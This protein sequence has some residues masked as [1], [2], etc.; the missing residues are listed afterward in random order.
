[1]FLFTKIFFPF[2]KDLFPISFICSVRQFL[3]ETFP[4]STK[5]NW[6]RFQIK[7]IIL[8][9]L[10]FVNSSKIN[11]SSFL[12]F[13]TK[14]LSANKEPR[15][16][17]FSCALRLTRYNCN[18][19]IIYRQ[20]SR[21]DSFHLISQVKKVCE[22]RDAPKT[23]LFL[24]PYRLQSKIFLSKNRAPVGCPVQINKIVAI[25]CNIFAV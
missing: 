15:T 23:R 10:Y 2:H 6:K 13:F 8:L 19:I 7:L 5:N 17:T 25:H 12:S 1:M 22:M 11:F 16:A 24:F 18:T 3:S 4:F 14:Q 21:S 9:D 20:I